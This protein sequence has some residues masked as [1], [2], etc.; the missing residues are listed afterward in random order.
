MKLSKH[1]RNLV[2]ATAVILVLIVFKSLVL[3]PYQPQNVEEE[4]F[5]EFA[6]TAAE[7]QF[8]HEVYQ[9]GI[10]KIRLVDMKIEDGAYKGKMRKY[11]LGFVP[12]ADIIVKEGVGVED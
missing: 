12:Y 7:Q 8:T 5:L 10:V 9:Y 11:A 1:E 6:Y 4:A 3:D 2:L